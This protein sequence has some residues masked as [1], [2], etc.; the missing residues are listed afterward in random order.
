MF[1][2]KFVRNFKGYLDAF[3]AFSAESTEHK[4]PSKTIESLRKLASKFMDDQVKKV[5]PVVVSSV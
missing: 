3:I 5:Q 2:G 1:D 4:I